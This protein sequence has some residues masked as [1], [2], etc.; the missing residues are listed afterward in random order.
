MHKQP[1]KPLTWDGAPFART[2]D[3][4]THCY[5]ILGLLELHR[6]FPSLIR[7]L[8]KLTRISAVVAAEETDIMPDDKNDRGGQD[9]SRVSGEEE[10]E[11]RY[12]ADKHG[13]SMEQAQQLIDRHGNSRDK[14]DEAVR[15]MRG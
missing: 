8:R 2:W 7:V 14:L 13:I 11:V 4:W 6:H 9:R 5:L 1:A 10:Y 15:Q 3:I 12:F